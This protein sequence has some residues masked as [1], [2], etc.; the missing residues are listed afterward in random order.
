MRPT[1]QHLIA[2]RDASRRVIAD[3][4]DDLRATRRERDEFRTAAIGLASALL[5]A[6]F[7]AWLLPPP[8]A[9]P[10]PPLHAEPDMDRCG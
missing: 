3:L 2:E 10:Q 5:Y 6:Q 7:S 9:A 1:V 4:A 8:A